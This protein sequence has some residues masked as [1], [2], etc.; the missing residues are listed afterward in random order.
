MGGSTD[1]EGVGGRVDAVPLDTCYSPSAP[2]NAYDEMAKG[3]KC[4]VD[5]EGGVCVRGA[6]LLC[7]AGSWV[8]LKDGPCEPRT[9]DCYG[10]FGSWSDCLTAFAT[11]VE[12]DAGSFCG[13]DMRFVRRTP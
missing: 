10:E 4:M 7:V 2:E 1:S 5:G 12:T 11:C 8:A 3:C 6:S 13:Y 9:E